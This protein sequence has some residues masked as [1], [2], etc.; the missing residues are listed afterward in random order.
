MRSIAVAQAATGYNDYLF[1]GT[2]VQ[3]GALRSIAVGIAAADSNQPPPASK[4]PSIGGPAGSAINDIVNAVGYGG[5]FLSLAPR[6]AYSLLTTGKSTYI[7]LPSQSEVSAAGTF[8]LLSGA[9]VGVGFVAAPLEAAIIPALG[10]SG[11]GATLAGL[12]IQA[13]LGAGYGG[14]S[15]FV[16]GG[17]PVTGAALGALIFPASGLVGRGVS[18]LGGR[19]GESLVR[20]VPDPNQVPAEDPYV[21]NFFQRAISNRYIVPNVERT[22]YGLGGD[23]GFGAPDRAA[24]FASEVSSRMDGI[25]GTAHTPYA[26]SFDVPSGVGEGEQTVDVGG[27]QQ[28]I[29]AVETRPTTASIAQTQQQ[30]IEGF[31]FQPSYDQAVSESGSQAAYSIAQSRGQTVYDMSLVF[32]ATPP[33]YAF[34]SSLGLSDLSLQS[35]IQSGV[36]GQISSSLQTQGLAILSIQGLL[37]TGLQ[38]QTQATTQEQV[39]SEVQIQGL[40]TLGL[41]SFKGDLLGPESGKTDLVFPYPPDLLLLT[42][43]KRKK[44][45]RFKPTHERNRVAMEIGS[46]FGDFAA[47]LEQS[48]IFGS[49]G[50]FSAPRRKRKR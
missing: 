10:L 17:N 25:S 45:M 18:I 8:G 27:G 24:S 46:S 49:T 26:S 30:K 32:L 33:G 15:S 20:F 47:A 28:Q 41:L 12:G 3:G 40:D 21:L 11:S 23:E 37:Q 14:I 2:P 31:V 34:K 36:Q 6:E 4:G 5:F 1:A 9:A 16:T 13:G 50:Y 44:S 38:T 19:I 43:R 22:L 35:Q 7:P 48:D 42:S 29:I 39:Q